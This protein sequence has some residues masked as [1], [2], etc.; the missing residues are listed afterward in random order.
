MRL[1]KVKFQKS[2]GILVFLLLISLAG[3][4]LAGC[5]GGSSTE[6]K[7]GAVTES[8]GEAEA[9]GEAVELEP[10]EV[11]DPEQLFVNSCGACHGHDGNGVIGPAIRGTARSVEEVEKV[12]NEGKGSM[13]KF[14]GGELTEEQIKLIANYVKTELK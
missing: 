13:P 1:D 10:E 3:F 11:K 2:T 7:E 9:E 4:M 14:K 5:S 6:K 8:A 12:I